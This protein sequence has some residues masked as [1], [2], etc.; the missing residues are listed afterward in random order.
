MKIRG[1]VVPLVLVAAISSPFALASLEWLEGNALT[2]YA[3][4]MAG[5]LPTWCAGRTGWDR[6]P[7]E[8]LT[9]DQCA[10]VNKLTLIEYGYSVL[11]CTN[12]DHLTGDRL[13]SL[14]L[15]AVNVGKSGACGSMA[16]KKIN[17]GKI[18]EGCA[19]IAKRPDGTPNWSYAGGRY[20]QGLQNRRLAE[21]RLCLKD[22]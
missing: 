19:L 4:N 7:G 6:K 14:T 10:E 18:K 15:F 22:A 3:D 8:R 5:G 17:E 11:E 20:V 9:S 2:V 21:M 1:K 12:W 13:I 16:F